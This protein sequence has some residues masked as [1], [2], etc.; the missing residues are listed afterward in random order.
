MSFLD[1]YLKDA[2]PYHRGMCSIMFIEALLFKARICKQPRGPT[3]EEWIQKM[4]FIYTVEY[5]SA[6][7]NEDIM[8]FA[9]KWKNQKMSL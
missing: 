3:T 6:I 2:P 5:Y 9:C 8:S 1:I 4:W 7:K